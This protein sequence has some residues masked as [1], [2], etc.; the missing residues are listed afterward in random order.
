MIGQYLSLA[1]R[2][3][4]RTKL[5]AAIS[6]TGLA[7]G[8]AAATLIGLH[9]HDEL[10]YERWLPNSERIYQVSAG[11]LL[12]RATGV[13][14]SDLAIWLKSDYP[15][16]EAVT[17]LYRDQRFFFADGEHPERKFNE[18]IVWADAST[19]D[20]FRFPVAAGSL[21]GALARPDSLVLTRKVAEKYFHEAGA[22]VSKT[23]LFN[24][25]QPMT[26]TAVI[27]DLPSSTH[28]DYIT[29]LAA[30]HAEFS[31]LAEQ[32]RTP[33]VVF[34]AK[35]WNSATYVLLKP[36]EPIATDPREPLDAH[37]SAR[38]AGGW[39]RPQGER[40]LAPH[41]AGRFERFT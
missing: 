15:Q 8:F 16:F 33:L 37:R 1:L 35:V 4:A 34:G 10:N 14:P 19:F 27:E 3:V 41:R 40:G 28:L 13:A 23:L 22:A 5:Y 39:R 36:G 26:V 12:G 25:E 24:G 30:A 21:D 31:P 38:A 32:D 18:A 17:R 7:I 6:V 29:A 9:I 2:N 20:V 11:A